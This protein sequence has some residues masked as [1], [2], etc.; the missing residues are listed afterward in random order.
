MRSER[1]R[2]VLLAYRVPREPSTPRIA[3]W[4]KLRR[5]G[6]AQIVDGLVAVP[7]SVNNVEQMGW[8]ANDILDAGGEAQLWT[9]ELNSAKQERELVARLN[10]EVAEAYRAFVDSI[11]ASTRG[12]DPVGRRQLDRF[13]RELREIVRRDHLGAT[14]RDRAE[15]ALQRLSRAAAAV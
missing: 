6:V 12:A 5:L 4:R 15:R 9:A 3:V 2:W 1:R 8:I 11:D 7:D 13:Q 10:R 14:G